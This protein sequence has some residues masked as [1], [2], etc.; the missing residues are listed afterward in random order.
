MHNILLYNKVSLLFLLG[1]VAYGV[2]TAGNMAAV[3]TLVLSLS[4]VF[5]VKASQDK[6]GVKNTYL[7]GFTLTLAAAAWPYA[8]VLLLAYLCFLIKPLE[9]FSVRKIMAMLLG[10]LSPLWLY[11]PIWLYGHVCAMDWQ[12][13]Q[14]YYVQLLTQV[15]VFDYGDITV[16]QPVLYGVMLLFFLGL[17][18]RRSS[19]RYKGK[20]FVR[21]QRAVYISM[22]WIMVLAIVVL[23][24]F[25]DWLLPLMIAFIGPVAAQVAMGDDR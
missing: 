14:E 25:A 8:I 7:A 19:Y 10:V 23:P 24:T 2:M 17:I 18:V 11:L 5:L 12:Q 22:V 1:A 4:L 16:V 9:A 6:E 13:V 20:L 3:V 15:T 21:M